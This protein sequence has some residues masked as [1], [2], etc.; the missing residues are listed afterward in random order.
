MIVA[1]R[2]AGPKP[3]S[4]RESGRGHGFRTRT[5][6]PDAYATT[7]E[8]EPVRTS[9]SKTA[10]GVGAVSLTF[11]VRRPPCRTRTR[12]KL[13]RW[14]VGTGDV[15]A[16]WH[17]P[18]SRSTHGADAACGMRY[19]VCIQTLESQAGTRMRAACGQSEWGAG[20]PRWHGGAACIALVAGRQAPQGSR[21]RE[22]AGGAAGRAAAGSE[23]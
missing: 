7:T 8:S 11:A 23:F 3:T 20:T 12:A 4:Q 17:R 21:P 10:H 14:I 18:R 6:T 22:E 13:D 2:L 19:A 9:R 16:Q 5:R 15:T 1:V